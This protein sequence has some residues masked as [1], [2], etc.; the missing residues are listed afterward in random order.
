MLEEVNGNSQVYKD[1]FC[2]MEKEEDVQFPKLLIRQHERYHVPSPW[3]F[4]YTFRVSGLQPAAVHPCG[5]L[6]LEILRRWTLLS[7]IKSKK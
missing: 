3:N 2:T 4:D 1:V 5:L 7:E 6:R